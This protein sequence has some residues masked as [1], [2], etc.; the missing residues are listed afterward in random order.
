MNFFSILQA[1]RCTEGDYPIVAILRRG[2]VVDPWTGEEIVANLVRYQDLIHKDEE[3]S[4]T[5][6]PQS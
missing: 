4:T 6:I 5:L 3:L 1:G 2:P